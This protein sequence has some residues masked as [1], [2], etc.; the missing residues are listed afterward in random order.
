M[1]TLKDF[2]DYLISKNYTEEDSGIF[3]DGFLYTVYFHKDGRTI[4]F[5][6]KL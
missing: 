3:L 6:V 1:K 4:T 5:N 2:T